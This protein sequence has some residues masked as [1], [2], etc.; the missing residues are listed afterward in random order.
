MD[1]SE[2]VKPK[3]MEVSLPLL[4]PGR[5]DAIIYWYT[6]DLGGGMVLDSSQYKSLGRAINYVDPC[7]VDPAHSPHFTLTAYR[8]ESQVGFWPLSQVSPAPRRYRMP[9][10]YLEMINDQVRNEAYRS[11]I[12]HKCWGKRVLDVGA[13]T[14]LL[15]QMAIEAGAATL[16]ACEIEP[17]LASVCKRLLGPA[18]NVKVQVSAWRRNRPFTVTTTLSEVQV[19]PARH[20]PRPEL[21]RI[22]MGGYVCLWLG[23]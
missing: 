3:S 9:S 16:T 23:P 4:S 1:F 2:A 12:Q 21:M 8:S 22:S 20:G 14:G 15:S 13:G 11:A 19:V 10:W 18:S 5:A 7:P 17:E 6:L